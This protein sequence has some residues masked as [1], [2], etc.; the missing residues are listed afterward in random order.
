MQRQ[1]PSGVDVDRNAACS[2]IAWSRAAATHASRRGQDGEVLPALAASFSTALRIGGESIAVTS[3]GVGTKVEVAERVGRWDTLG[4]DLVA[5]VAD[6]LVCNGAEPIGLTNVLDVDRL[7]EAIVDALLAGLARAALEARVAILGGEIAELGGRVGGHGERMRANWCAT[8]IGT[9]GGRT[10]IDGRAVRAGDVVLALGEEGLRSNGFSFARRT[11]E[12]AYGPEWHTA[13]FEGRTWGDLLLTPSR[14][15][16]PAIVDALRA[17]HPMS[18]LAH[19][20]GGGIPHKLGRVLRA[21][22]RGARLHAL[23]EPPAFVRELARLAGAA[24]EV[25]FKQWNLGQ[26]M[27]VVTEAR[28]ADGLATFLESAGHRVQQAG[29][30]TDSPTLDLRASGWAARFTS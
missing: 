19:V 18:G 17:G 25:L 27:L 13:D 1:T 28:A 24:P 10:P 6:D 5:M 22:G 15:Y 30:V 3:D 4:F 11:L 16:G 14:I 2:R 23:F 26:G 21:T 29:V 9:F 8:A 7:D 12:A 20:T